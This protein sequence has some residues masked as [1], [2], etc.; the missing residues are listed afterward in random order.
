MTA[1][2]FLVEGTAPGLHYLGADHYHSNGHTANHVFAGV[3]KVQT[4][5]LLKKLY[6]RAFVIENPAG[7]SGGNLSGTSFMSRV[8]LGHLTKGAH[9][10]LVYD[11]RVA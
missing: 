8:G 9:T 11:V 3:K 2:K 7:T 6:G 10:S 4:L 5:G 1:D